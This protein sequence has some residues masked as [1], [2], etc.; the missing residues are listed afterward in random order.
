MKMRHVVLTAV[1]GLVWGT[2]LLMSPTTAVL[3]ACPALLYVGWRTMRE[4]LVA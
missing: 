1:N 3:A 2:L 4:G